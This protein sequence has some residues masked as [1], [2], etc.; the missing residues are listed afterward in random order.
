MSR[1]KVAESETADLSTA[2]ALFRYG[3]IAQLV[4]TPPDK[5]HQERL[6]REL[7]AHTYHIPGSTRTQ[8]SVTTLRRYLKASAPM[9]ARR[10]PSRPRSWRRPLPCAK[11]NP[12]APPRLWSIFCNAIRV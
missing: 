4:H 7:A 8:V 1:K 11:N 12:P 9:P 10:G 6:L 3:L 5:G 2:I